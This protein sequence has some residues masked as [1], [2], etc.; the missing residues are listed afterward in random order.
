MKQKVV[1]RRGILD[2]FIWPCRA[3][4]TV[5][6]RE[7]GSGSLRAVTGLGELEID[8]KSP[9]SLS[10]HGR[11]AVPDQSRESQAM[12]GSTQARFDV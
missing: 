10:H 2:S 11:H 8:A 1:C 7:G 4:E 6:R 12:N 5:A 9:I 3:L